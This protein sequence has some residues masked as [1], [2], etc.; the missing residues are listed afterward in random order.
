MTARTLIAVD[1]AALAALTAEVA[2][3]RRAVEAVRMQPRPEWLP[4]ADYAAQMGRTPRTVREWVR[5]GRIES[6]REGGILLIRAAS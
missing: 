6:R 2:A 5:A 3:L 1:E 4:I